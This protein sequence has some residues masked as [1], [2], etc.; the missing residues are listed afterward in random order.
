MPMI[1]EG[2]LSSTSGQ[3]SH[4]LSLDEC[5]F[6]DRKL[7]AHLIVESLP[8]GVVNLS[9][10]CALVCPTTFDLDPLD[11]AVCQDTKKHTRIARP[12][13]EGFPS[14]GDMFASPFSDYSVP[15]RKEAVLFGGGLQR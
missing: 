13:H 9:I 4:H 11:T 2:A 14:R 7:D 10:G 5:H 8:C 15:Q 1:G 6:N 12:N 3:R